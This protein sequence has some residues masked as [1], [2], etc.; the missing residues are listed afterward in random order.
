VWLDRRLRAFLDLTH[1]GRS[2]RYVVRHQSLCDVFGETAIGDGPVAVHDAGP[3]PGTRDALHR[4]LTRAHHRITRALLADIV[5]D[6]GQGRSDSPVD[7]YARAYL[8]LHAAGAGLLDD[9]VEDPDFL[10]ACEPASLRRRKA[11][12]TTAA[13]HAA[14]TA[15]E[16]S[17]TDRRRAHSPP[18]ARHW[19]HVWARKTRST[20]LAERAQPAGT[21]VV[22]AAW[23]GRS[24]TPLTGHN[25]GVGAVC[26]VA[27]PD[28]T[29][30]LAS[31]GHDATVRLWDPGTGA[32]VGEP[33]VGHTGSVLA[34]CAV[35]MPDGTTLLATGG[36]DHALLVWNL[37]GVPLNRP[38]TQ[39][40]P[41]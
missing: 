7:A 23:T 38:Q 12:L 3:D 6:A 15:Y 29:T 27:L 20:L 37:E 2:R 13:G 4:A 34:V 17:T 8:A 26:A 14:F 28:G 1:D 36:D 25:G 5:V 39:G 35:G 18:E 9:L 32:P 21:R 19:L 31:G 24:H 16:L 41:P 11:L 22:S 33:L 40:Q 10:L 30:S